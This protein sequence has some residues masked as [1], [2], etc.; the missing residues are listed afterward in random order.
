VFVPRA[1]GHCL[2]KSMNLAPEAM[3]GVCCH[4]HGILEV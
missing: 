4:S 1:G 3:D 2:T